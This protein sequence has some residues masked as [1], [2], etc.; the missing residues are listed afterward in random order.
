MRSEQVD[1]LSVILHSQFFILNF[2][3]TEDDFAKAAGVPKVMVEG[4]V[5]VGRV[6]VNGHPY[7][8]YLRFCGRKR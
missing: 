7:P 4:L 1:V 3:V 8:I 2:L 5:G 6:P